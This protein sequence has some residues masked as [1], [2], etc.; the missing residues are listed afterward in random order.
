MLT[1]LQECVKEKNLGESLYFDHNII[2]LW[3]VTTCSLVDPYQNV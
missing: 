2:L 1:G 3:N